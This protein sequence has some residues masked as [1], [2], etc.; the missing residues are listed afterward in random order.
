[1]AKQRVVLFLGDDVELA[2]QEYVRRHGR[3]FPNCSQVADHLLGRALCTELGEQFEGVL[4]PSIREA[5]RQEIERAM[6]RR[7]NDVLSDD[8]LSEPST[9][10]RRGL[11]ATT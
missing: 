5:V 10:N 8:G 1:M 6:D 11:G 2:L 7:L 3:R 4:L 9:G